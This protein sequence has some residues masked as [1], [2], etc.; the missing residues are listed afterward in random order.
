[1]KKKELLDL[2]LDDALAEKVAAASVEELKGYVPMSR[3]N[4]VNEARKHAEDS[5]SERDKQIEGLKSA[6]GDAEKLKGQIEKLQAENKQKDSVH[7]AEIQKLKLDAAVDAALT[8]A[9]AK[10]LKAARA[11]LN[12]DKAELSDDGK[13]KGLDEQIQKLKAADDSK[14]LFDSAGKLKGAKTGE[15]GA[16]DGEKKPDLSAMSY[17]ELAKYFEDNPDVTA[18]DVT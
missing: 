18:D 9:K 4:E 6:A 3:F 8:A 15:S 14:F 16:E 11:L 1:M 12:L 5:L 17:T 7:A 13:V 2:G 10:N